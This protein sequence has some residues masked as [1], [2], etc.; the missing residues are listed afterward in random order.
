MQYKHY[1]QP[2]SHMALTDQMA[3]DNNSVRY[4]LNNSPQVKLGRFAEGGS[5][6]ES[7]LHGAYTTYCLSSNTGRPVFVKEFHR[8][9]QDLQGVFGFRQIVQRGDDEKTTVV[10]QGISLVERKAA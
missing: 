7:K 8:R 3:N 1:T 10:Y 9:M 6:P 2:T 5:V 4:W